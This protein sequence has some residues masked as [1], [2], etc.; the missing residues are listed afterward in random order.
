MDDMATESL[1]PRLPASPASPL[2]PVRSIEVNVC[3]PEQEKLLCILT[4]RTR[5]VNER[6]DP[7]N[8]N[9]LMQRLERIGLKDEKAHPICREVLAAALRTNRFNAERAIEALLAAIYPDPGPPLASVPS[10]EGLVVGLM[11]RRRAGNEAPPPGNLDGLIAPLKALELK[12]EDG[13]LLCREVLFAAL[14]G[15]LYDINQ[16]AE[17]LLNVTG[18]RASDEWG[19]QTEDQKRIEDL[20][21]S[22]LHLEW[23]TIAAAYQEAHC[24]MEKTMTALYPLAAAATP[25]WD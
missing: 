12:D 21:Q 6:N 18:H 11:R 25:Q 23:S 9:D 16:A 17:C 2:F 19:P 4:R 14:D 8:M 1:G 15:A 22:F 5:D 24:D 3:S 7:P 10:Q 13:I 20:R